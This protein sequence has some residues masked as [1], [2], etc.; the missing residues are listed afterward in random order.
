MS[1]NWD[2]IG[3]NF[4]EGIVDGYP[5]WRN[6]LTAIL[7]ITPLGLWGLFASKLKSDISRLIYICL[8]LNGVGSFLRHHYGYNF[9]GLWDTVTLNLAGWLINYMAFKALFSYIYYQSNRNKKTVSDLSYELQNSCSPF[10]LDT[11]VDATFFIDICF[12]LF[13]M[14]NDSVNGK[15]WGIDVNFPEGFAVCQIL[16]VIV[17]IILAVIY[18]EHTTFVIYMSVGLVYLL[19]AVLLWVLTEPE[20]TDTKTVSD[21]GKVTHALWHVFSIHSSHMIIQSIFFCDVLSSMYYSDFTKGSNWFTK[22]V[23]YIFPI[24]TAEQKIPI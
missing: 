14:L 20:C 19:I 5:E 7:F 2:N 17:C 6:S 12:C 23:Y 24:A 11:I 16:T 18:R 10:D 8:A 22:I 13:F 4:C 15:P 3:G 21:F 1:N 9:Y